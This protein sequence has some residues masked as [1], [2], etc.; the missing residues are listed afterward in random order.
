[1]LRRTAGLGALGLVVSLASVAPASAQN[2][3]YCSPENSFCRVPYPTTVYYGYR[4]AVTAR[5]VNGGVIPCNN[6]TF[7][8]PAPGVPK[9]CSFVA[10]GFDGPRRGYDGPRREYDGPRR[11]YEGPRRDYDYDRRRGY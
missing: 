9:A 11:G 1:M 10:R 4:G 5:Q 6:R 7:G 3:V 2:L 8:D